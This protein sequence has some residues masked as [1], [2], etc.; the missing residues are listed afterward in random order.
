MLVASGY[1]IRTGAGAISIGVTPSLWLYIVTASAAIFI[2]LGRRYAELRLLGSDRVPHRT[3]LKRYSGQFICQLLNI[4]ATA[5]LLS[6]TLYTIEAVNLPSNG[7]MLLTVP[8]VTFGLFRY[9]YLL[10]YSEEAESPERLIFQDIPLLLAC[11][12]WLITSIV[13]LW[14]N[15]I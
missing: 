1:V 12:T 14:V 10:N 4:S 7:S 9:L 6:Y 3:V 5:S 11:A 13:V 8:M 15:S 2:V